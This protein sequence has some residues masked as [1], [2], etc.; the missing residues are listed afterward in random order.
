GPASRISLR[1]I[2]IRWVSGAKRSLG[3]GIRVQG[4]PGPPAGWLGQRAPVTGISLTDCTVRASPQAGVIMMGVS[5]I[6]VT[7]LRVAD[8]AADGLHFNACRHATIDDFDAV[9]TGDD[10]LALV[11]YFAPGFSFDDASHTFSYPS[12]NQWS[13]TEFAI[14][15]VSV[16]DS[17]ANGVRLAGAHRVT[18]EGL[19]VAGARSGAAVLVDSA[20][21]G[22]DVGWNYVASRDIRIG[23]VTASDCD[24]GFHLLA[25]PA[26]SGDPQFTDFNVHV[27]DAEFDGCGNWSVRVE[28]LTEPRVSGLRVQD[29]RISAASTTGGRGGVGIRN[30]HGITLGSLEIRHAEPVVTFRATNASELAV[31][32]LRVMINNA[33]QPVNPAAPWVALRASDG[34]INGQDAVHPS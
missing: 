24:T 15:N 7:G 27:D 32:R 9:G 31:D 14:N 26:D 25:R 29:C 10:G 2:N 12:L 1:N 22:S 6:T 17:R 19:R 20:E 21:P 16:T 23:D 28:S 8:T 33:E 30:A 3:D 18:V 5:D 34:V 11:T 4:F 13:N